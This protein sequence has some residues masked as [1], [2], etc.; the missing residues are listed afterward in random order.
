MLLSVRLRKSVPH[1]PSDPVTKAFTKA[2]AT[3]ELITR[4]QRAHD[5][6]QS[7]GAAHHSSLARNL[8]PDTAKLC[9][10]PSAAPSDA[11]AAAASLT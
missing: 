10:R 1:G 6:R 7:P 2:C 9:D 8:T 11:F 3:V 5:R 4:E